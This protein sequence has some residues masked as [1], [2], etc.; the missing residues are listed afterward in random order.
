MAQAQLKEK[1]KDLREFIEQTNADEGAEVLRRDSGREKTYDK[2][3]M[4]PS[5]S[6]KSSKKNQPTSVNTDYIMS[7]EYKKKFIGLTSSKESDELMCSKAR[8]MLL[9]RNNTLY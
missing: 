8:D 5:E 3:N 1:Q 2:V 9:H 7:E 6:E 4:K